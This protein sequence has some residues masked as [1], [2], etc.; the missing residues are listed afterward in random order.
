MNIINKKDNERV[1]LSS[2]KPG[3]TFLYR[4]NLHVIVGESCV[5]GYIKTGRDAF[6]NTW[7]SDYV[8]CLNLVD[9]MLNGIMSHVAVFPCKASIVIE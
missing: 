2:L 1:I 3:D 8:L 6:G 5:N 7:R 9:N 4:D